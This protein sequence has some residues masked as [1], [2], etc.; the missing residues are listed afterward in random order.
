MYIN[1]LL[2]PKIDKNCII[3]FFETKDNQ[4]NKYSKV[5]KF[6]FKIID[7][8]K[9]KSAYINGLE[10]LM[11]RVKEDLNKKNNKN[12]DVNDLKKTFVLEMRDIEQLKETIKTYFPKIIVRIFDSQSGFN[13]HIDMFSGLM[14]INECIYSERTIEMIKGNYDDIK[15]FNEINNFVKGSVD[16]KNNDNNELYNKMIFKA[17]WRIIMNA[18]VIYQS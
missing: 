7:K 10:L 13:S 12:Y 9:K 4:L 6:I 17:F 2:S 8:L 5:K 3:E 18:L 14:I 15:G 1:L 11:S 16:L